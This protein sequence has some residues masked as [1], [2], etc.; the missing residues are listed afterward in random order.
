MQAVSQETFGLAA[1]GNRHIYQQ[2]T[3]LVGVFSAALP[4]TEAELPNTT[5]ELLI[6]ITVA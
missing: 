6:C 3:W 1:W 4:E 5:T 2:I